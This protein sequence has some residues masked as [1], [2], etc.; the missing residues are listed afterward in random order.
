M[1]ANTLLRAYR[2]AYGLPLRCPHCGIGNIRQGKDDAIETDL[3]MTSVG[4]ILPS[5]VVDRRA[6]VLRCRRCN[7][8]VGRDW[9]PKKKALTHRPQHPPQYVNLSRT[10]R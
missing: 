8:A 1:S 9:K 4:M 6:G 2:R 10:R 7:W 5:L 3:M